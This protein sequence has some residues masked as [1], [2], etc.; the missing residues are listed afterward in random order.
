L[1]S[2]DGGNKRW[3]DESHV[4]SFIERILQNLDALQLQFSIDYIIDH[5]NTESLQRMISI[6]C[7]VMKPTLLCP[8]TYMHT[9]PMSR[10]SKQQQLPIVITDNFDGGNGK[11]VKTIQKPTVGEEDGGVVEVHINIQPDVYTELEDIQVGLDEL[12]MFSLYMRSSACTEADSL[13]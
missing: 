5:S 9:T 8:H 6:R 3:D 1:L 11:L 4:M 2:T 7:G 10:M 13:A 12:Y